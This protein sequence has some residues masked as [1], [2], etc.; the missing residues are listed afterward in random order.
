MTVVLAIRCA[1]GLVVG[2]DSQ[3]TEA[4]RDMTYPAQKLHDLGPDAV[5]GGSGA[6]SV[7]WDVERCFRSEADQIVTA[8]DVGRELQDRVLPLL[9][10]HYD[11]FITDVPG[12]ATLGTPATYVLAAGYSQGEPFIVKIDPNGAIGRYEEIGFH[13]VGSGAS[14]AQQASALLEHFRMRERGVEHGVVAVLRVLDAL[15][16]SSPSVGPPMDVCR[17]T[18]ED[19]AHH[20]DEDE[21][22]A[23]REHVTRWEELEQTALDELFEA[24]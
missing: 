1:D 3:I 24:G 10:H 4:D 5:W 11:T 17:I 2:S 22:A 20:L 14:M 15:D 6:R 7:L 9:R 13:A 18:A 19:G 16:A 8:R 21:I 12:E 23:V